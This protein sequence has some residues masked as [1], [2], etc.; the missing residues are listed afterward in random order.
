[1]TSFLRDVP[2]PYSA[3]SASPDRSSMMDTDS[4]LDPSSSNPSNPSL[5]SS[6]SSLNL[7]LASA[8]GQQPPAS[9]SSSSASS[10]PPLSQANG[11]ASGLL[12]SA[13]SPQ[14]KAP[15]PSDM[16]DTGIAG[17]T[18]PAAP[19]GRDD[20]AKAEESSGILSF[21]VIWN[22]G[23]ADHLMRLM[24]LKNIFS[25]QL[26]KMPREYIVRL[27]FDRNHRSMCIC[28]R[29]PDSGD[30]RVVGGICFRPFHSQGFAEI[31]FCL[32]AGTVVTL[33]DGTG[34]PIESF[35]KGG[36][37]VLSY[38]AAAGGCVARPTIAPHRFD[39]GMKQCV[40]L[41][42]EDGRKLVCT[43]DHVVVTTAGQKPVSAL[44]PGIDRVLSAPAG[45]V[46]TDADVDWTLEYALVADG[47]AR[48]VRCSMRVPAERARALAFA[49]LLGYMLTVASTT[50]SAAAM[51]PCAVRVSH[52]LDA[53]SVARDVQLCMDGTTVAAVDPPGAHGHT[54][55]THLPASLGR[56]LHEAGIP[57]GRK[58]GQGC[59]LPDVVLATDTPTAFVREF[60]GA[61]FGGGCGAPLLHREGWQQV[62]FCVASEAADVKQTEEML[63]DE[64]LP[65]LQRFDCNGIIRSDPQQGALSSPDSWLCKLRL[66]HGDTLA[67]ADNVG[68]R[69]CVHE[70]QRLSVAAGWYRGQTARI[71]Q[72]ERLVQRMKQL[73]RPFIFGPEQAMA[74]AAAE[75]SQ[76][77]LLFPG[78]VPA[79]LATL[80]ELAA[81]AEQSTVN[82]GLYE[83]PADYV[84]DCGARAIF[85]DG[86]GGNDKK[87]TYAARRHTAALPVWSVGIIGIRPVGLRPTYDLSVADTHLFVADGLVVHNCA[88]TATEQVKGYGTR[89]M[90]HLKEHVKQEGVEYFLTYAD[91]YAIGYFK[92]QGF[93]KQISMTRERW[94]GFIKDYDG[95]TLMECLVHGNIDYL[96]LAAILH[97]QRRVVYEQI[98]TISRSHVVYPGLTHW[99]QPDDSNQSSDP[100]DPQPSHAAIP[101]LNPLD[102]PGVKETGYV[103]PL[104]PAA[105]GPHSAASAAGSELSAKLNLILKFIKQQKDSWP[106]AAPVDPKLVPDYYTHITQPMDLSEMQRRLDA[107]HYTDKQLFVNDFKLMISNCKVTQHAQH[108][109][110]QQHSASC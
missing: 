58:L 70:Q 91:N 25:A 13:S 38:D 81:G 109:A 36:A 98:K 55:R 24:M 97:Q 5:S 87:R 49:R 64:L 62:E 79:A 75:E 108:S 8:N 103:P 45:P 110:Q 95:G 59:H 96:Q 56:A 42:L 94:L 82:S 106:F 15:S 67:F 14:P 61:L 17:T 26:P 74:Q 80:S 71:A 100:A 1:M 19:A 104:F 47:C 37:E 7:T 89:L 6:L 30:T 28:K 51:Y 69:H 41:L 23:S 66:E 33:A 65:L 72:R 3:S 21:P 46:V 88:I 2:A 11:S 57:L 29:R 84:L 54:F 90:N 27:V 107:L 85:A 22:D 68:F 63:R 10:S 101:P 34:V 40:E 102:V 76:R 35:P 9:S 50:G 12:S 99:G 52:Q 16:I 60:L 39:Q 93:S 86:E 92:K 48:Q 20:Y 83:K 53:A 31:V 32:A 105:S 78:V 44:Q 18:I 43:P 4:P 73:H 77:E